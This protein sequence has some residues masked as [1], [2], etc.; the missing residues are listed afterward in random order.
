MN[1]SQS[2]QIKLILNSGKLAIVIFNN[3]FLA[4]SNKVT[5]KVC[6]NRNPEIQI[7]LFTAK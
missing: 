2:C 1:P 7:A 4:R 6:L 3:L 5:T